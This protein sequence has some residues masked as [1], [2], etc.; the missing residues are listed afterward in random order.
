MGQ[1][2]ELFEMFTDQNP[3]KDRKLH[4]MKSFIYAYYALLLGKP[5]FEITLFYLFSS[6]ECES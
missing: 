2:Y 4:K 6:K 1:V 5:W 3:W